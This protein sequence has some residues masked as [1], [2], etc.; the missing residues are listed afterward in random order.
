[1]KQTKKLSPIARREIKKMK[2]IQLGY[3]GNTLLMPMEFRAYIH[4]NALSAVAV[5]GFM[6]YGP[7]YIKKMLKPCNDRRWSERFASNADSVCGFSDDAWDEMYEFWAAEDPRQ[8][9]PVT[10]KRQKANPHPMH[11]KAA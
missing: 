3:G 8:P 2:L 11:W 5:A 1:M 4:E 9:W 7:S 6:G 10:V